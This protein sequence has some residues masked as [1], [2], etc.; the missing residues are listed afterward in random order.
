M[1]DLNNVMRLLEWQLPFYTH[2]IRI[3]TQSKIEYANAYN[4]W[5]GIESGFEVAFFKT[6]IPQSH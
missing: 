1:M 2:F 5:I 4:V 3:K 6:K